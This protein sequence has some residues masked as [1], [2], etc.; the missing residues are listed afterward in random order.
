LPAGISFKDDGNGTARIYGTTNTTGTYNLTITAQNG[1]TPNATQSLTIKVVEGCPDS[2][3]CL[4][5]FSLSMSPYL[6]RTRNVSVYL[7]P[8]YNSGED[9][10]VLYLMDAQH[11]FGSPIA[12]PT[13]IDDWKIDELLDSHY[14][15]TGKGVIAVGVWYDANYPWSEYTLTPNLN[16]DH[17]INGASRGTAP[18]GGA[19][20]AFIR[21]NVKPEIDS[22]FNTLSDRTNTAIGGG[23]R[24]ALLA[25]HAGLHAPSTFSKVMAFS[26]AVWIAEGGTRV[27]LPGLT[28]WY[29]DNGLGNWFTR[30]QA[31]TDVKY[32]LYV[33]GNEVSTGST[34]YDFPYVQKSTAIG[35]KISLKYAYDSGYVR[36]KGALETEG[37]PSGNIRAIRNPDGTHYPRV[38]RNYIIPYVLPFFGF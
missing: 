27:E 6:S 10:P 37:V 7:P 30:Y 34:I 28:T 15:S 23:S 14:N 8:N 33:G 21:D 2:G 18:E 36:I 4:I 38:W 3:S 24:C 22:R 32:F 29:S 13:D 20:I 11:M 25:L 35:E 12:Y 31:P 5:T 16:M 1:V 9:Y 17:W 26:T 19:M